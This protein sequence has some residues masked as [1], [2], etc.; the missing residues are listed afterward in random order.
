ML[1]VKGANDKYAELVEIK[2]V[3]ES[4]SDPNTIDVTTLKDPVMSY[5]NGRQDTSTQSFTYNYTEHNYFDLVKPICD[6]EP[7]EFLVVFPDGTGTYI[8][9]VADTR[10]SELSV[11]SAIEATLTITVE[12]IADKTSAEVTALLA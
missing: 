2:N 1:Y 3:P 6:R 8:K 10:K 5:I 7:K 4:G 12:T 9:G 11:N